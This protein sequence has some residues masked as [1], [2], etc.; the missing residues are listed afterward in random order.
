MGDRGRSHMKTKLI[1]LILIIGNFSI[2]YPHNMAWASSR[3]SHFHFLRPQAFSDRE[4]QLQELY[5]RRDAFLSTAPNLR[6]KTIF[7]IGSLSRLGEVCRP[8][9]NSA[10]LVTGSSAVNTGL[11]GRCKELLGEGITVEGYHSVTP[12]PTV[13]QV[14]AIVRMIKERNLKMIIVV[15]GGSAMDAAKLAAV[16]AVQGGTAEEYLVEGGRTIDANG[17]SVPVIVVPTTS[18]S[19]SELSRGAIISWPERNLKIGM[20]NDKLYAT[21]AVVDPELAFTLPARETAFGG[22][23]AFCHAVET[24]ISTKAN[25][26]AITGLAHALS[27]D[28]IKAVCHYLPRALQYPNDI[29]ARAHLS[30]YSMVMGYNLANCGSCAPHRMQYPIGGLTNTAHAEGLA[31]LYPTWVYLTYDVSRERFDDISVCM[32]EGMGIP[33]TG[34]LDVLDKF[35]T[36]IGVKRT[37][38]DLIRVVPDFVGTEHEA[39]QRFQAMVDPRLLGND[40]GVAAGRFTP[41]TMYISALEPE[42][43]PRRPGDTPKASDEALT[44]I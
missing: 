15:G 39:C 17:G 21:A 27:R 10:L 20:F 26:E 29:V 13:H 34:V 7:G 25:P 6:V 2:L 19:G 4:D 40:P 22:F 8:Y 23:D 24:Y 11:V 16:I 42:A 28:A 18:A 1:S 38:R 9:G 37:L 32:A 30:Y 41:W 43:L 36:E 44:A 14:N 3:A 5:R 12:N 31:A 33:N 35:M